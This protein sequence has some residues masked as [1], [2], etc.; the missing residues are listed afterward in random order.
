MQTKRHEQDLQ[1]INEAREQNIKRLQI[2]TTLSFGG[3]ES[4]NQGKI[5]EGH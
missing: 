2:V 1:K 4:G 5:F 3:M